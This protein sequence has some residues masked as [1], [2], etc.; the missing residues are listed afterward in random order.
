MY[1][2]PALLLYLNPMNHH[3]N[4]RGHVGH[5]Y[6][7]LSNRNPAAVQDQRIVVPR[8]RPLVG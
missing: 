2:N 6:R 7:I 5:G 4:L 1:S 3:G 8:N